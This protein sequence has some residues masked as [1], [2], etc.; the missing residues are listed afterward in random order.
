MH[1]QDSECPPL[2]NQSLAKNHPQRTNCRFQTLIFFPKLCMRNANSR[3]EESTR[4]RV[5]AVS[6]D[7]RIAM[8]A[9]A[10]NHPTPGESGSEKGLGSPNRI[11]IRLSTRF[12]L[13]ISFLSLLKQYSFVELLYQSWKTASTNGRVKQPYEQTSSN[14]KFNEI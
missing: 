6:I 5:K 14:I 11:L 3:G 9:T 8:N 4:K 1:N 12:S 7:K 10:H 2:S 13:G